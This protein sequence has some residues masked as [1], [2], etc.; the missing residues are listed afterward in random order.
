MA[1]IYNTD[2]FKELKDGIKLQQ[3]RDAIPTQ[4]AEKIVPVME[5][6]PKLL[7]RINQVH[8]L[9]STSSGSGAIFTTPKDRDFYFVGCSISV[10]SSATANSTSSSISLTPEFQQQTTIFIVNK[11][12]LTAG[13]TVSNLFLPFPLKLSRNTSIQVSKSFTVGTESNSFT[14]Y[15][16]TVDNPLS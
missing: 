12:T 8:H 1:K 15:G 7:R 13:S 6:N 4:L 2:L 11:Q 10:S 5:V 3:V 16:Y 9:S 14:V